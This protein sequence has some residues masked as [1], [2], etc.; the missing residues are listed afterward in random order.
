MEGCLAR[1]APSRMWELQA[2]DSLAGHVLCGGSRR[3]DQI[4]VTP[5]TVAVRSALCVC[6]GASS[7]CFRGLNYQT[8]T[9]ALR[10]E[11]KLSPFYREG[12]RAP[13]SWRRLIPFI[14]PVSLTFICGTSVVVQW[15]V[16]CASNARGVGLIPSWGTKIAHAAWC[17]KNK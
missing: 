13:V 14:H 17:S 15:L 11:Y 2:A 9:T 7:K 10:S 6:A 5:R 16:L 1:S 12:T 4:A 3:R 8:F